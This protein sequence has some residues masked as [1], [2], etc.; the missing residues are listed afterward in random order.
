LAQSPAALRAANW[1]KAG[2]VAGWDAYFADENNNDFEAWFD[3]AAGAAQAA[4]GAN[5]G[6]LEGTINLALEFGSL[7]DQVY[8]AVGVYQTNDGGALLASQ[9]LPASINGDGNI[10]AL[11]YFRL[12]FVATPGDFNRDGTVDDED[13]DLWRAAYGSGDLRADGNRD[14]QVDAADYLIWRNYYG[15]SGGGFLL[16]PI[17]FPATPVPEPTSFMLICASLCGPRILRRPCGRV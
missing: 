7:P 6:V 15:T 14:G 12:Q 11:E 3:V 1:A 16:V 8:L 5:G 17:D 2:Q 10:D 4:T 13:Y 9:Q